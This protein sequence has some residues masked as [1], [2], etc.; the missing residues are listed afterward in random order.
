MLAVYGWA[1]K[2][3]NAKMAGNR[4]AMGVVSLELRGKRQV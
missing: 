4:K 3:Q 2:G 1:R